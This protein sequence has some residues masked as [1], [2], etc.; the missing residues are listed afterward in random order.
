MTISAYFGL[1][2][3]AEMGTE[4]GRPYYSVKSLE[5]QTNHGLT[6]SEKVSS[7][8]HWFEQDIDLRERG[9][10]KGGNQRDGKE[11]FFFI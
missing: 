1:C 5:L 11:N 10:G 4:F 2:H 8:Q 6:T 3:L 9:P 7:F